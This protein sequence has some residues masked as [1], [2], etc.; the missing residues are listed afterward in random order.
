MRHGFEQGAVEKVPGASE[1]WL[2]SGQIK[3]MRKIGE[4][5]R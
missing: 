4:S 5:E 2:G 1:L 3:E